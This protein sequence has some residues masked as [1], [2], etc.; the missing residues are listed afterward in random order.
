MSPLS[1]RTMSPGKTGKV[2]YHLGQTENVLE[3]LVWTWKILQT[4]LQIQNVSQAL[5]QNAQMLYS[6][7][8]M[9]DFPDAIVQMVSNLGPL[10]HTETTPHVDEHV[11]NVKES[12]EMKLEG[13]EALESLVKVQEPQRPKEKFSKLL[14]QMEKL[15]KIFVQIWKFLLC[16]GKI[17]KFLAPLGWMVKYQQL[18]GK[19]WEGPKYFANTPKVL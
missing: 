11:A 1:Q 17:T 6:L 9:R 3:S 13:P 15:L 16:L 19:A 4:L 14:V 7:L 8:R 18:P 12:C 10:S 2:P 5:G